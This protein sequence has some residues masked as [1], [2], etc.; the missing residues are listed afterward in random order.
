[1]ES[2]LAPDDNNERAAAWSSRA[3]AMSDLGQGHEQ[4]HITA[5]KERDLWRN[6]KTN[7]AAANDECKRHIVEVNPTVSVSVEN[8]NFASKFDVSVG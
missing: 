4:G 8:L 3:G 1:M 5:E 7:T 6:E 2:I